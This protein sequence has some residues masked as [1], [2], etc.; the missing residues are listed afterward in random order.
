MLCFKFEMTPIK[1]GF[2]KKFKSCSIMGPKTLYYST[3]SLAKFCQKW[4]CENSSFL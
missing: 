2:L 4:L 1:I 3:W